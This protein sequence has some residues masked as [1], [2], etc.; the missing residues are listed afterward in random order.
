MIK[1]L[2]NRQGSRAKRCVEPIRA[3]SASC[4]DNAGAI[5]RLQAMFAFTMRN[6]ENES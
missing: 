5:F 1:A 3:P 6:Y 2:V 4:V